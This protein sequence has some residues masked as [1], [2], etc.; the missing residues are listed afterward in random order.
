MQIKVITNGLHEDLV[1]MW[2]A[3]RTCYSNKSPIQLYEE[4]I[5]KDNKDMVPLIKQCIDSG[6]LSITEHCN[7]TVLVEGVSRVLTHQLV[8]HRHVSYSQQS[9]RYC[10]MEDSVSYAVPDSINTRKDLLDGYNTLMTTIQDVYNVFVKNG[11]KPEDARYI[12]PNATKSNIVFTLNLRE[13]IHICHERL[14]T[15]AQ[16]EIRDLVLDIVS[17]VVK[18][19]P[20]LKSYLVPKCEMLGYCNE[21]KERSCGRKPLK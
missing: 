7:I 15:C 17:Q 11:I 13:F 12:L 3:A 21:R 6:H 9:Q 18:S 5:L 1:K 16:K 8:R 10:N 4:A 14:C 19:L 2:V 20:F